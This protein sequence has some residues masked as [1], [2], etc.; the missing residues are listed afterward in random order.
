MKTLFNVIY[1][2]LLVLCFHVLI[3]EPFHW[4]WALLT[5]FNIIWLTTVLILSN[6]K[7]VKGRQNTGYEVCT[8]YKSEK[9]KRDCYVLKFPRGSYVPEHKDE[10]PEG[11]VHWR[12]N[13]VLPIWHVGGQFRQETVRLNTTVEEAAEWS[14]YQGF[15][16]KILGFRFIKFAPS[17]VTHWVEEV[18]W[19]TRFV[20]SFGWLEKR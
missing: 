14:K 13:I 8:I 7:Y 6:L 2:L 5:I 1:V 17:E 4:G 20:L 12:L 16:K 3:F 11:Y 19:H 10:A 18:E 9:K 15:N